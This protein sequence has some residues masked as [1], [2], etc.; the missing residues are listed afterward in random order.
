MTLRNS[1]VA[2]LSLVSFSAARA[3]LKDCPPG[4]G[5]LDPNRITQDACQM[6]VDVFQ[7]V[8]PQLGIALAGGN[9]TLGQG[10]ALGGLGHF[11]VG[12]RANLLAGDLPDVQNF[13]TPSTSGRQAREL[14]TKSQFV[15][16]PTVDAAIGVFK[17]LPLGLTNVG[18]I[19]VLLSASYIPTVGSAGDAVEVR[20]KQNLQLGFGARLGLLQESILVPGVSVTY[21]RRDLPTTT[22]TGTSPQV[23][24]RVTDAS[25]KTNAWRL[26]ASKSLVLFSLA[27]GIGQDSY[28]QSATVQ[29]TVKNPVAVSSQQVRLSQTLKRTNYFLDASLNMLLAKIVAEIGQVSGGTVDT[30]NSFSGGRADKSRLYGSV[31]V[32]IGF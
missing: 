10:G 13:P 1:L 6:A 11:T 23:D 5:S 32:R 16:L 9:A 8:A 7:F 21:L 22:V 25:V 3:Q 4:T 26:T 2:A 15:G 29:G 19:D 31:G 12:L 17:G 24:V 14:P 28:D 20:P 30:F 18:G 27:A